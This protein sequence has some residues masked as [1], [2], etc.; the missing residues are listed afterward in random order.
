MKAK[1]RLF[2]EIDIF[3]DK[4]IVF[5]QGIIGFYDMKHFTL[6]HD[7][8]KEDETAIMWLQSM[9]EP[10]FALP[11][12]VPTDIM[13]DYNPTVNEAYLEQLGE[14][15]SEDIYLLVTVT[16]PANIED[17]AV[18]LKAPIVINMAT[19]K[20]CQLITEDEYSVK[21]KIYDILKN[22][23]QKVGE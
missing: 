21:Y 19:N 18:N 22:G 8:E 14:M 7:A 4:I 1:T 12:L 5:E 10:E 2:G 9:D 16:V 3:D 17:I 6:I 20:A 11:V 15:A 23:K 13:V